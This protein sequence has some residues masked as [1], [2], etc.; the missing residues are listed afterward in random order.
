MRNLGLARALGAALLLGAVGTASVP[1]IGL[2]RILPGDTLTAIAQRYHTSVQAL[3]ALNRLPGNGNLIFAGQLLKVPVPRAARPAAWA[4][5]TT[6]V[7]RAGDTASAV[8]ARYRTTLGWLRTRNRL[9]PD[10]LILIGQRLVVP[11]PARPAAT[12]FAGRTYP[13]AV[14]AAAARHRFLLQQRAVPSPAAVRGLIVQAARQYGVEPALA[15][16]IADQESGFQQQVVSPADAI[17]A[18]QVIPATGVYVSR[19]VVHRRLDLLDARDNVTAG[20]ALLGVLTRAAPLDQAVAGYYQGLG[21]VRQ[22][23]MYA[24]TTRYVRNVLSLR[25]RYR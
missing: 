25:G 22:N 4:A 8:A 24:D 16:A 11:A 5:T 19:Y 2:Y 9:G 1:G 7:V 12:S 21:S 13:A 20:V 3:V 23:G 6:Y 14:V 18:M 15:L 17:G 10:Y